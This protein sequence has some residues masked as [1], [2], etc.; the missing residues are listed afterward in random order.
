MGSHL[1]SFPA[2]HAADREVQLPDSDSGRSGRGTNG[3][4]GLGPA[5][6][7]SAAEGEARSL[8]AVRSGWTTPTPGGDSA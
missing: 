6:C 2:K 5:H 7:T 4:R 3:R 8:S 1:Y